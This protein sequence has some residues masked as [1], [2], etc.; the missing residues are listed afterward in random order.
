[1]SSKYIVIDTETTGLSP[2]KNGLIQLAA[3]SLNEKLD[4]TDTF[5]SDVCP[6]VEV[7]ISLQALEITGFSMERISKGKSYQKVSAAFLDFL[8]RNFKEKPI[9]IGQFYPF[10][11]AVLEKVFNST[12]SG[13]KIL[14]KWLTNDFIDTKAIAHFLNLK[15]RMEGKEVP[16]ISTS[17]SNPEGLRKILNLSKDLLTHDALGDILATREALIKMLNYLP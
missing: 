9:A 1:M 14:E 7:N 5:C 8:E 17:L 4:I 16:F 11:Y 15:A 12:P 10:D 2:S 13:K 3:I 6:E